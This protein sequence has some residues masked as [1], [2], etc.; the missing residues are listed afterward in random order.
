MPTR[1]PHPFDKLRAGSNLPPEGEGIYYCARSRQ[2]HLTI[3]SMML[4]H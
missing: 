3:I 4:D 2:A 1:R